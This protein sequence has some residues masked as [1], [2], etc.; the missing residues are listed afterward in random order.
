MTIKR[1]VIKSGEF[2]P[3][4][5]SANSLLHPLLLL[6]HWKINPLLQLSINNN[7]R[8]LGT[9][10]HSPGF[11]FDFKILYG[12]NYRLYLNFNWSMLKITQLCHLIKQNSIMPFNKKKIY[13]FLVMAALLDGE[14]NGH[15]IKRRHPLYIYIIFYHPSQV[16]FI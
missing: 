12:I 8:L 4:I 10:S 5:P 3:E 16:W 1:Y 6:D 14:A 11:Q 7:Q 2:L 15:S 13:I 9:C